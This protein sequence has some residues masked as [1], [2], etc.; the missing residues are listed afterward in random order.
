MDSLVAFREVTKSG[1]SEFQTLDGA[2]GSPVGLESAKI[3]RLTRTGQEFDLYAKTSFESADPDL[4]FID[5]RT[6]V[7]CWESR[8]AS[9][10]DY[11]DLSGR[12][13]IPN[14]K[15]VERTDLIEWLDGS[16]DE[17]EFI[18]GS[19]EAS[20][21]QGDG[22]VEMADST[23]DES[24]ALLE[25]APALD[26]TT[27]LHGPKTGEF[28]NVAS[29]CHR[30]LVSEYRHAGS[31]R[32]TSSRSTGSGSLPP[33]KPTKG[34][35]PIILLSP[36]PSSLINMANVQEFLE[37]GSFNPVLKGAASSNLL[38]VV[39]ESKMIGSRVR[40]VVVDSVEQFKPEYWDRVV[41]VFVTGQEWQFRDYRWKDPNTL[42]HNVLGFGLVYKNDPIPEKMKSCNVKIE[43]LDRNA[44][45]RDREVVERIW[46]RIEE[47]MIS[48][49]WPVNI[50]A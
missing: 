26:H 42:F 14:L 35:D 48:R 43:P 46:E 16:S 50:S 40:F 41:A 24:G 34:K 38:R 11:I 5:L 45:F 9:V 31:S 33:L 36:S 15:F 44:R 37:K 18:R 19:T 2:G 12:R 20:V 32:P 25:R 22:D 3:L 29:L 1:S 23:A 39:R 49:G 28:G 4:G 30:L 7:N 17:S 47:H 10:T 13:G 21:S 27:V 8:D 6:V